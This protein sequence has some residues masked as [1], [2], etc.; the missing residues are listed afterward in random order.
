MHC[1]Y[2]IIETIR[3]NFNASALRDKSKYSFIPE[4]FEAGDEVED[5]VHSAQ[6]R[7]EIQ[8]EEPEE[9]EEDLSHLSPEVQER[10]LY[11][12]KK[13]INAF[14]SKSKL[15]GNF[16]A[17]EFSL[18]LKEGAVIRN[19]PYPLKKDRLEI[20]E[21]ELEKLEQQGVITDGPS[22]PNY[23]SPLFIVGKSLGKQSIGD[24]ID[25]T[26]F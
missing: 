3:V 16:T 1:Y 25:G 2:E 10:I 23:Y 26:S 13:Y 17:K 21:R 5:L 22:Q 15:V 4:E 6:A 18:P 7:T 12:N 14:A 24:V 9:S 8:L 11:L 20:L 19:K